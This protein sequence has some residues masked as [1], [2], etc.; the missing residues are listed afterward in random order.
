LFVDFLIV[1]PSVA[2]P[3]DHGNVNLFLTPYVSSAAS[4]QRSS[5][6]ITIVPAILSSTAAF[7]AVVSSTGIS[8]PAP[9]PTTIP[10]PVIP[11]FQAVAC[12]KCPSQRVGK[13]GLPV[14]DSVVIEHETH[15]LMDSEILANKQ[16]IDETKITDGT[17]SLPEQHLRDAKQQVH[18]AKLHHQ[19]ILETYGEL[20]QFDTKN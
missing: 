4:Y 19:R 13:N 6:G 3:T 7:T 9:A 10:A 12:E 18:D 8:I 1:A 11:T 17:K 14:I 20:I 5:T 15:K 16:I 2:I